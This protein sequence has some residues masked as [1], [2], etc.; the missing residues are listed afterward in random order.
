[1]L[2]EIKVP[3]VG[4]SIKEG[5]LMAWL[6]EAGETVSVDDPLFELETD[7]ITL[8]V[9]A[10]AAGQL[11][12]L[13]EAGQ[14]ITIGQVV[15]TI[16]TEVRAPNRLQQTEPHPTP[17]NSVKPAKQ[18]E[19]AKQPSPTSP[20]SAL[21][22]DQ[23]ETDAATEPGLLS[24][25]VRR[26]VEEYQLDFRHIKGSG[27]NG[28]LTKEDVLSYLK[29]HAKEY[30]P[31]KPSG[32]S[33][34][35]PETVASAAEA[36][37]PIAP[38]FPDGG[39][40]QAQTSQPPLSDSQR[41]QTRQPMSRIRQRI[42][43]RLVQAQQTAAILT[44]FNEADMSK[45][46]E[47]RKL[48]KEPFEKRFGIRLGLMSFFVKAAVEA[49][50][51]FPAVNAQID[52]DSVVYNHFYDIG[53][54]VATEHGL[55]VPIIRHADSLSFAQ[56]EKQIADYAQR[57]RLRKLE[58]SELQGGTFTISNGGIFGSM[59]STPILN[60]PQS[61]ILGLHNI[62]KRPVAVDDQIVLRPMMYL[63]LTY[64]HRLVDGREAVLF[65]RRIIDCIERPE[66][67]L[68][69]I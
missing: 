44:T 1:M 15:G 22:V 34:P 23:E 62:Q 19:K 61:G 31:R 27:K 57:A 18:V 12:I 48:Y 4:E 24:P 59:L 25:A 38:S 50:K 60:P 26:M 51:D 54:A 67:L 16:D 17:E 69:E 8:T 58:L 55:V 49:L 9:Q 33:S 63:A 2:V 65:L 68:L 20:S 10:Q 35:T 66:R 3:E 13:V 52:G 42:A 53:V 30:P 21:F 29:G 46:M 40:S 14:P 36:H 64:D 6:T 43:E 11:R 37:R 47:L 7:K 5:T 41:P 56:I 39:G 28:R 32:E 45:V